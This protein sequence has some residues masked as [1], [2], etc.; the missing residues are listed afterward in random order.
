MLSVKV[1]GIGVFGFLVA[2]SAFPTPGTR[3]RMVAATH[4]R[5]VPG[6]W[7]RAL[8]PFSRRQGLDYAPLR[9]SPLS[10]LNTQHF[11]LR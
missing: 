6:D 8:P 3:L 2:L 7:F 11:S 4:I 1:A 10:T 9:N 5:W